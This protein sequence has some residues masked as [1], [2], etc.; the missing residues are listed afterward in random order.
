VHKARELVE[1]NLREA[2]RSVW[3]LHPQY[4]DRNDIVTGLGRLAVDL[5]EDADVRI[6]VRTSGTPRRLPDE[7]EKNLFRIAQEAVANAIR[8]AAARQVTVE[9]RFNRHD[10]HMAVTDDGRGV[11]PSTAVDGFGLMS[12]RE[13]AAQIGATLRLQSRPSG[14]TSVKVTV[15]IRSR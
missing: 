5:G 2:R 1:A 8:H 9:L 15:P 12:M 4:L 3:D 11:D 14:G 10:V 7:I 13:R 6:A